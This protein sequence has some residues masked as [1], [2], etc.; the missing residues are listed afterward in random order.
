MQIQGKEKHKRKHR[1]FFSL[2]KRHLWILRVF[3][4]QKQLVCTM[5]KKRHKATPPR[6]QSATQLYIRRQQIVYVYKTRMSRQGTKGQR[7]D[8]VLPPPRKRKIKCYV[9]FRRTTQKVQSVTSGD[10]QWSKWLEHKV[11][12][13]MA[14]Q[15]RSETD[16]KIVTRPFML[17]WVK[18][19]RNKMKFVFGNSCHPNLPDVVT[20][21]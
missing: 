7:R 5:G 6:S 10:D 12:R 9:A 20:F 11:P 18:K 3:V 8:N 4:L 14:H 16:G 15:R 19:Q 1:L 17:T 21:H 2:R 13:E